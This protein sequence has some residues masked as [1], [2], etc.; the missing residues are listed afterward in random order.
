MTLYIPREFHSTSILD[1]LLASMN[2]NRMDLLYFTSLDKANDMA[3]WL[4]FTHRVRKEHFVVVNGPENDFVVMKRADALEHDHIVVGPKFHSYDALSYEQI[5]AMRT[6]EDILNH[7]EE[8]IGAFSTMEGEFLRYILRMNIPLEKLIRYE[9]AVRGYDQA[10]R[11]VG[12]EK[13]RDIWLK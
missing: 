10:S 7:W 6:D 13:A 1:A 9:L 8:I 4:T 2:S 11:W 5:Q 12:F 3:L